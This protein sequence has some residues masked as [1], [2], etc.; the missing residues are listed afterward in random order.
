MYVYSILEQIFLCSAYSLLFCI[1]SDVH[2][3]EKKIS[4]RFIRFF[5][6]IWNENSRSKKKIHIFPIGD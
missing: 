5:F 2:F 3:E 6:S 4:N 1:N